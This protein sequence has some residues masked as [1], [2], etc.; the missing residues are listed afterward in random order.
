MRRRSAK[1]IPA[2]KSAKHEHG[3]GEVVVEPSRFVEIV[4][5]VEHAGEFEQ[6]LDFLQQPACLRRGVNP[7]RKLA[8][9]A[10]DFPAPPC[11]FPR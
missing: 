11:R 5:E 10:F 4:V 3:V 7:E 6:V 1:A 8:A 2:G 9:D